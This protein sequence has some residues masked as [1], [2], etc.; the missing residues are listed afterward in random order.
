MYI[1]REIEKTTLSLAKQYPVITLTG[2]R[3]SGKTTLVKKLFKNHE[4]VTLEDPDI[5]DMARPD[6]RAFLNRGEK[7]MVID[8]VQRV[9]EILSYI[10][11]IVDSKIKAGQ[12]ILT[13]SHQFSLFDNITQSLAG[14]TAILKLLPCSIV[15][16]SKLTAS[17]KKE[18]YIFQGFY[19]DIYNS[20]KNSTIFYRNYFETYIQRDLRQLITIKDLTV[21]QKFVRLCAGRTGQILNTSSLANDTGISVPTIN[22]WLSILEAS[23]ILF[24]LPPFFENLGK[25]LIKSPKLYFYDPGLAAYLLGIENVNQV[26]RDPLLGSLFENLVICDLIKSR[27]NQALDHNLFFYR[28]SNGVEVDLL[29]RQSSRL[30]P[31][32]IKSSST[33]NSEFLKSLHYIKNLLP[34]KIDTGYL[35]YAGEQQRKIADIS[36]IHFTNAD[37]IFSE[38]QGN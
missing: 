4:Y 18:D 19:P 13:G 22:S 27:F 17:F 33:F 8:E 24:R 3:Q 31:I 1:N 37:S 15:E 38:I 35:V 10:Q 26:A 32:E 9:P 14:R 36:L 20:K 28:D 34:S 25:R 29:F 12:F 2:P 23:Y 21:F 11:G 7:G 6:A 30:I 16:V 5:R